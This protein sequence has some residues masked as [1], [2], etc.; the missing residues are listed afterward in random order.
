MR[1]EQLSA[2]YGAHLAVSDVTLDVKPRA[3]TAL[4]GPSGCGKS[5]L[6]RCLNRMHEVIPDATITGRILLDGKDILGID[7]V[8]LRRQVGMVFQRPNPFPTMSVFENVA[9]GLMLN[10]IGTTAE[11][12]LIVEESLR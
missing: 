9:A 2:W 10:G 4:I 3:V 11:R 12:K 1:V 5:T 8:I 6:V 7:P